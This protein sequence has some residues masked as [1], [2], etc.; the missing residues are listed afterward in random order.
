MINK[1]YNIIIYSH[2]AQKVIDR[3]LTNLFQQQR[4]NFPNESDYN[5]LSDNDKTYLNEKSRKYLGLD[6]N[7][8]DHNKMFIIMYGS[9]LVEDIYNL[10]N[11]FESTI[12]KVSAEQNLA[13]DKFDDMIDIQWLISQFTVSGA[14]YEITEEIKIYIDLITESEF[15]ELIR[16]LKIGDILT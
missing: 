14:D 5:M 3:H 9:L 15:T 12:H 8:I 7:E 11:C 4:I 10:F 13:L 2:F 1:I 16:D 6:F